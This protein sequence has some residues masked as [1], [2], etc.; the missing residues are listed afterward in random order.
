MEKLD[1][2]ALIISLASG[3]MSR[4][5]KTVVG[6]YYPIIKGFAMSAR[7]FACIV[8]PGFFSFYRESYSDHIEVSG[9]AKFAL[10]EYM[11]TMPYAKANEGIYT[12]IHELSADRF[13]IRAVP[14]MIFKPDD[15]RGNEW[16]P[17]QYGENKNA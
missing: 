4:T 3:H 2:N 10:D 17:F 7:D 5:S 8:F 13:P 14:S 16:E 15:G 11:W 9:Y 6:N 12:L 1:E